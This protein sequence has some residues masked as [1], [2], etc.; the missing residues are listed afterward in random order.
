MNTDSQT[1]YWIDTTKILLFSLNSLIWHQPCWGKSVPVVRQLILCTV[2]FWL[3]VS[4]VAWADNPT[5]LAVST[6]PV[7]RPELVPSQRRLSM[8]ETTADC[9]ESMVRIPGG[10]FRIGADD[11][12][13]EERSAASV[14]VSSFCMDTH[15][16]TNAQFSQFVQETGYVTVAE[17]PLSVE[18]FPELSDAQRR[19][20]SVVF[21]P[22]AAAQPVSELSWWQWVP[23]ADWRHPEGSGSTIKGREN[24]PVVHIAFEDALAHIDQ[25]MV[26]AR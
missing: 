19:P 26:P 4:P 20:G 22:P 9:P 8:A 23:G 13:P 15:E 10:T 14:T 17:R 16:V 6:G 11:Q 18:Q 5:S 25:E 3:V 21:Q 12:L 7:L 2:V 1:D 24:H